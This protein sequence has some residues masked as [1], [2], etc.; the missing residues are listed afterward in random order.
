M[1]DG[2]G[3]LADQYEV[4][5][6]STS[7]LPGAERASVDH[8]SSFVSL[9]PQSPDRLSAA[10]ERRRPGSEPNVGGAKDGELSIIPST[11][12]NS[13]P[14]AEKT[15]APL[16]AA[17]ATPFSSLDSPGKFHSAATSQRSFSIPQV[18]SHLLPLKLT[19]FFCVFLC[20]D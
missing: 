15:K 6:E 19:V 2:E 13:P 18:T 11:D 17:L 14:I 5:D 3:S 20:M 9:P 16:L 12:R 8:T 10:E 7:L 4:V 1:D